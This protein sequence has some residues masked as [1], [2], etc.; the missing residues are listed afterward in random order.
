MPVEQA[1]QRTALVT[2]AS[3]GIGES[4]AKALKA[5]GYNV[6]AAARRTERLTHLQDLG[7]HTVSLDVSD[8]VSINTALVEIGQLDVLVNNAGYG[9]YG[10][11]EEVPMDEARR[12]MEVN[13]FGLARM[14]QLVIPG[15][16]QT[17]RGT[18]I[19]IGSI[20]AYFGEPFGSWYH[21]SKYAVE[22]LSDSVRM[23]VEPFGIKVITIN[24]GII[25]SEW[26]GIAADNL[27]KISGAGPYS[28]AATRKAKSLRGLFDSSVSSPPEVVATKIVSVL[29]KSNPAFR[30]NVGGGA[31]RILFLRRFVPD[32]LF[33]YVLNR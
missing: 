22:G 7:I 29:K 21:A 4:I 28:D 13:V 20:G 27:A 23:E 33:Y 10:S 6:Y 24:P 11:L 16:R 26:G 18:I 3:S 1:A 12:Q 9:S 25:R 15:M 2:G 14:M 5:D 8:E 17:K 32:R 30:Y 31:K 19:N